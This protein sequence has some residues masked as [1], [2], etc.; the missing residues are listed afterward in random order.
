M[1]QITCYQGR[2]CKICGKYIRKEHVKYCWLNDK[3]EYSHNKCAEKQYVI[4][5]LT[6]NNNE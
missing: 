4:N 3:W 1:Q 2:Q 6:E 5:K